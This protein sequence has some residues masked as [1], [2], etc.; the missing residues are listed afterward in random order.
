MGRCQDL[1]S[2]GVALSSAGEACVLSLPAWRVDTIY[3]S[4]IKATERN[5]QNRKAEAA[6]EPEHPASQS[7]PALLNMG[8][9]TPTVGRR[10]SL[11]SATAVS[12]KRQCK[13]MAD[14]VSG[15]TEPRFETKVCYVLCL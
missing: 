10:A 3:L 13:V 7:A 1:V 9:Q 8:S 11:P 5:R 15:V 2:Q 4:P 6:S 14:S 12:H